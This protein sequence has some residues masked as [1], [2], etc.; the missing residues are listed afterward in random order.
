M[1]VFTSH[2]PPV[3][4]PDVPLPEFLLASADARGDHPAISSAV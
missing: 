3:R 2:W 1:T 4:V